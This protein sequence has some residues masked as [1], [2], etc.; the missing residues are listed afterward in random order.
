M[1]QE[2]EGRSDRSRWFGFAQ[3]AAVL[4]LIVLAL[5]FARAPDRLERQS[6]A[7][8]AMGGGNPVV[9]VIRP[10]P[11]T[12]AL[13]IRL[14][15]SV[16][17]ERKARVVSEVAGRVAWVSPKF[18]NGGSI[19]AGE[20]VLRIDPTEFEL[21]VEAAEAA[22]REAQGRS[23]GA[24]MKARAE[25]KLAKLNLERTNITFPYDSRVVNTDIEVG[26]L[27]GPKEEGGRGTPLGV[28]YRAEALQ[29]EVPIELADLEHLSP[30]V[31]RSALLHVG[32]D[33]FEAEVVRVSWIVA[34]KT[35][36]ATLF[37]RFSG[38][39][40]VS[41]LPLPGSF[42]VA[43][44]MGPMQKNVFVLPESALRKGDSV[45]VVEDDSLVVRQTGV[46]GRV[47]AGWV[48]NA[49][50]AGQGIVVGTVPGAGPG[51]AVAVSAE[52]SS[53]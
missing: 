41:S 51:M 20:S 37:L 44:I 19:R 29:A 38:E 6:V 50:D 22:V 31:G 21:H 28:V 3:L 33:T 25:L 15:G 17:L 42:V 2:S 53:T 35:R 7:D 10:E 49:F 26:E 40:P 32:P 24:L 18:S 23:E 13:S 39:V 46:L 9:D 16:R 5:Y 1:S 47:G 8:T 43:E 48:T 36:L 12:Q 52:A 27:V 34:P 11:T 4:I 14:T 30:A 45:W